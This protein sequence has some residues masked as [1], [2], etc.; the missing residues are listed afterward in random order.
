MLCLLYIL[1]ESLKLECLSSAPWR[2]LGLAIDC[3]A[4]LRV[5]ATAAGHLALGHGA[6]AISGT[7]GPGGE[8]PACQASASRLATKSQQA[9][10]AAAG[11]AAQSLCGN[12]HVKL[13]K[14][15]DAHDGICQRGVCRAYTMHDCITTRAYCLCSTVLAGWLRRFRMEI[16][17]SG[18]W[19]LSAVFVPKPVRQSHVHEKSK[20]TSTCVL[21]PHMQQLPCAGINTR[22]L[23]LRHSRRAECAP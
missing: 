21:S 22:R 11:L 9:R 3:A 10:P 13:G 5:M 6:S 7:E 15:E 8:M 23:E 2:L 4:R 14:C 16:K 19:R 18:V 20:F 17:R 12:I 1:V